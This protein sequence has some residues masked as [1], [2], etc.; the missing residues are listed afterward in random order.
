MIS[1]V[2]FDASTDVRS[3]LRNPIRVAGIDRDRAERMVA[4]IDALRL[5]LDGVEESDPQV[6]TLIR[7]L[8]ATPI[9]RIPSS[10][11]HPHFRLN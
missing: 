7:H 10:L 4:L 5:Y 11:S 9:G 6:H 1:D 8:D 2:L 3:Y